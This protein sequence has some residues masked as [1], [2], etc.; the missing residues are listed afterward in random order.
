M[1]AATDICVFVDR[2]DL[3]VCC[4]GCNK[5]IGR[6]PSYAEYEVQGRRDE[7]DEQV[8]TMRDLHLARCTG[9]PQ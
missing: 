2:E 7:L 4:N 3:L 5:V 1:L 8:R 6:I 9:E